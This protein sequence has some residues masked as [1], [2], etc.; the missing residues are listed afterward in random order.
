MFYAAGGGE[1]YGELAFRNLT[2]MAYHIDDDGCPGEITGYFRRL[3]RGGWQT[4]C[5][6][7]VLHNFMD[8]FVAVPAWVTALDYSA[9]PS[10]NRTS[11]P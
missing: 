9:G 4:D 7:D 8:A 10:P 1:E 5:H 3:R 6:C 2:W 11:H